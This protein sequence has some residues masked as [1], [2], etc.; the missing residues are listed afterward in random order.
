[1]LILL[2]LVTI[3][4]VVPLIKFLLLMHTVNAA[5]RTKFGN[6]RDKMVTR[7]LSKD[8]YIIASVERS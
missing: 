6:Y 3:F 5:I 4:V 7:N 1:M 2:T 8:E